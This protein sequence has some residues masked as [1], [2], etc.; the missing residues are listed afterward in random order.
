MTS[1]LPT[2]ADFNAIALAQ[3]PLIDVR[4]PIEFNKGAI[5]NAVNLPLM[6]DDERHQVGECYQTQGQAQAIALGHQLVDGDIRQQRIAAWQAFIMQQPQAMLYCFRGGLRSRISQ[7]WLAETGIDVVRLAGGYKAFRQ[8]LINSLEQTAQQLYSN[9]LQAWV[10]AGRTGSGK[11]QLLN[12]LAVSVDLEG[13]AQHRGSTFGG[14]A[15]PQPSQIDFE[16]QLA[17]RLIALAAQ[18]SPHRVFE[19]EG[20]NIGSVHLAANLFNA[21]KSGKR[22]LLTTCYEERRANI[23]QEYVIAAQQEY[24]NFDTWQNHMQMRFQRIAKRLGGL[25]YAKVCRAFEHACLQQQ[26]QADWAGHYLW[27]DQLLSDYYD[28]MYDYQLK[29]YPQPYVIEGTADELSEFF[30]QL[31]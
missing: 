20:R 12:R 6:L 30:A 8:Y 2:T 26:T 5:P 29:R 21:I 24:D 22:V 15:W 3:T 11:T 16:N 1:I 13:L 7:A 19:D 10:I 23:W 25:G 18:A 28:P 9:Q 17:Y 4:A 27:I 31:A 14:H